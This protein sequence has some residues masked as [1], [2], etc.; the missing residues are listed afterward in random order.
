MGLRS[1]QVKKSKRAADALQA[2]DDAQDK[3]S[4]SIAKKVR[5]CDQILKNDCQYGA[6]I[7]RPH[8]KT[9][10]AAYGFENLYKIELPSFWR[11][12][13]TIVRDGGSR[14]VII[15]EIVDHDVYNKWFPS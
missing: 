11:L 5:A 2:L 7:P 6:V 9:L 13:Y 3:R 15:L 4:E 12:L 14:F 10:V 1:S 8:P